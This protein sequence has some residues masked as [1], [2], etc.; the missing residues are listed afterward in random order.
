[1]DLDS[2]NDSFIDPLSTENGDPEGG[3]T[4]GN[5]DNDIDNVPSPSIKEV[6]HQDLSPSTPAHPNISQPL[7]CSAHSNKG[8]PPACPDKDPK[9]SL[10]SRS[11]AKGTTSPAVQDPAN[12]SV[13]AGEI[14]N[15]V[16]D[17]LLNIV[18]DDIGALFLT[19]DAPQSYREAM[20]RN[21]A[22][23]WVE[24]IVEEYENLHR[25]GIFVEVDVP[26]DTR[27]HEG[28]LVFT[29]KVG[30]EGEITKRKAQLVAKG[31]TEVWGE[32]YWHTYSPTLGRDTLFSC[33]VYAA[34]KDLEI[35][36]LDAVAAYLNSDLTEEIYLSP[37]DGIPSTLGK[38][39]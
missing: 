12:A 5:V 13:G 22:D 14:G 7:Q 31:Y 27:I 34:S 32:D 25:K 1:M 35:H 26:P 36:Q 15:E 20:R 38:V 21:D 29:E 39:W 6:D 37:P 30:S 23:G 18:D 9:L 17:P 3:R 10:G 33:L 28:C 4:D 11:S 16:G 8:I 19:A 24:A 2:D